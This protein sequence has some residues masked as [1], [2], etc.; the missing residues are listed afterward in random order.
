MLLS[1]C[2]IGRHPRPYTPELMS[3]PA[4]K[5]R[6]HEAFNSET[7]NF[8][9]R[10]QKRRM[11]SESR[12]KSV[13]HRRETHNPRI[14]WERDGRK[15]NRGPTPDPT[16]QM[17]RKTPSLKREEAFRLSP[18][19]T[20]TGIVAE[21]AELCRLGILCDGDG[22]GDVNDEHRNQNGNDNEP[23]PTYINAQAPIAHVFNPRN[24][25]HCAELSPENLNRI[26]SQCPRWT[27]RERS[28]EPLAI[29]YELD[30]SS[31]ACIHAGSE[32]FPRFRF[33][34]GGGRGMKGR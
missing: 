7:L 8:T 14:S 1:P 28:A 5:R 12:V 25:E 32:R 10:P 17:R 2:P 27:A 21:N 16:V 3:Q 13:A 19:D 26:D 24:G 6:H 29:I 15:D 33:R 9:D 20:D 23:L 22:D 18:S 34:H 11:K 30:E 31:L 4:N